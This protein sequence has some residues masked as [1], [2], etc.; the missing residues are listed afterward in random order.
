MRAGRYLRGEFAAA[1]NAQEEKKLVAK[2]LS[3]LD[4]L[5]DKG[6]QLDVSAAAA[7]DHGAL[8]WMPDLRGVVPHF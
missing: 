6:E 2:F 3:G 4:K 5:F 7:A 8:H 1:K